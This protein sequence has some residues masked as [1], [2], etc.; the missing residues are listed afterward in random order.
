MMGPIVVTEFGFDYFCLPL[1]FLQE[2]ECVLQIHQHQCPYSY[3]ISSSPKKVM[4]LNHTL[5]MIDEHRAKH[6]RL[7]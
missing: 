7:L 1:I 5:S 4:Q 2:A 3:L 6:H